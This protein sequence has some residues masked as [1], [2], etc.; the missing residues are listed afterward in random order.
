[1]FKELIKLRDK[2]TILKQEQTRKSNTLSNIRLI[3]FA[4]ILIISISIKCQFTSN[5]LLSL[6]AFILLTIFFIIVYFHERIIKKENIRTKK[7][8]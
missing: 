6:I 8:W 2:Y 3:I 4:I 7:K 5:P 1:M